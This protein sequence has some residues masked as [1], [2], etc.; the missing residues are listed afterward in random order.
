MKTRNIVLLW[1]GLMFVL[2]MT[3]TL[4]YMNT[5][6]V[7]FLD[8]LYM[9]VITMSTVG[10]K[11]VAEMTPEAK[12]FSIVLI[13]VSVFMV[14]Y[15][16]STI[17]SYFSGGNFYESWRN[18]KMKK[19]IQEMN[20][21]IILCG[22]GETGLYVAK[23]LEL[24][25]ETF[26]IVEEDIEIIKRLKEL[27][28]PY[29]FSDATKE[30]SLI[31]ANI[32][33]ARGLITTL[34]KDADNVYVVLMARELNQKLHIIARAHED[35]AIKKLK[36]A[37]ANHTVSTNQIGGQKL[38]ILMLKPNASNFLDKII[39]TGNI[40][41]DLEEVTIEPFSELCNV[42]LK[43]SKIAEKTGLIVIAI[44]N[45]EKDYFIFNPKANQMISEKDTLIV[46][47]EKNQIL[48]LKQMAIEV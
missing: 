19:T 7:S 35:N 47:G 25:N 28:Y 8:A 34:P 43:N 10:F 41:L 18:K 44:K 26:V 16:L 12:I 20:Q 30:E 32:E 21:H 4:V 1:I 31:E 37:G 11:E 14:G 22:A 6:N 23:Q 17:V 5:L 38:A 40:H 42:E 33:N 45:E 2:V 3:S 27:D 36:R 48:K 15:L 9:T 24:A 46:V 29:V 39:D 13:I